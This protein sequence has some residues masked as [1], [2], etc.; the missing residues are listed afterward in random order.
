MYK[1]EKTQLYKIGTF[2]DLQT[3]DYDLRNLSTAR[4]YVEELE[5]VTT[6]NAKRSI[7]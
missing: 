6:L 7:N 5:H 4:R 2:E 1:K 3:F